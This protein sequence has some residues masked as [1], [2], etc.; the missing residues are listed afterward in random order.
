MPPV[1]DISTDFETVTDWL[2]P[3]SVAEQSIEKSLRR[4][5]TTKEIS[6]SG[7]RYT[8]RDTVFHFPQ[9]AFVGEPQLADPIVDEGK[10]WR[11]VESK[12]Q[13]LAN[14]W[15]CVARKPNASASELVQVAV[16]NIAYEKS[17][18]GALEPV[19]PKLPLSPEDLHRCKIDVVRNSV[20]ENRSLRSQKTE[21]IIFFFDDVKLK[22]NQQIIDLEGTIYKLIAWNGFDAVQAMFAAEC[23]VSKWPRA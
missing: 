15:R 1:L 14:R 23:E 3:I 2:R 10:T 4:E 5:I 13:T 12:F 7:G 21:V 19:K 18:T 16:Q 9:S 6:E 8:D 17:P 20:E 22:P 11:I